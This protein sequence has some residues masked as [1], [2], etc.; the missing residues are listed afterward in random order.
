MVDIS[1]G[2][3]DR[4]ADRRAFAT[5][6][7]RATKSADACADRRPLHRFTSRVLAFIVVII[8]VPITT[9][10][11]T[12][13]TRQIKIVVIVV[14]ERGVVSTPAAPVLRHCVRSGGN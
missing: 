9:A 2:S 12:L 3:A 1:A 14:V 8:I 4:R 11:V 10:T 6:E 5:T 7:Q 13:I